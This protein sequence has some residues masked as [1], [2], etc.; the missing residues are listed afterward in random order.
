VLRVTC[1]LS[2]LE[3]L[4]ATRK[5]VKPNIRAP[6]ELRSDPASPF[7]ALAAMRGRRACD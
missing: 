4:A 6:P 5:L 7:Q 3:N 1:F 2:T